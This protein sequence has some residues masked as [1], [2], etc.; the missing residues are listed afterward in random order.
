MKAPVKYSAILGMIQD[1][2]LQTFG[3]WRELFGDDE[4]EIG[5]L[6]DRLIERI[7][8]EMFPVDLDAAWE[9]YMQIGEPL[10]N[11]ALWPGSY[12]IVWEDGGIINH[13]WARCVGYPLAGLL[14]ECA[15]G[16]FDVLDFPATAGGYLEAHG[17]FLPEGA[18]DVCCCLDDMID[19]LEHM[20]PPLNGA[21]FVLQCLCRRSGHVFIDF[22]PYDEESA[23]DY[24]FGF[25]P[26]DIN[27]LRRE[28]NEIRPKV[29]QFEAYVTWFESTPLAEDVVLRAV[30]SAVY[31][32]DPLPGPPPKREGGREGPAGAGGT[33]DGKGKTL[34]EVF[35]ATGAFGE[36]GEDGEEEED[37]LG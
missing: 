29:E 4:V 26:D 34:I 5:D 37:D 16:M 23:F 21:A 31:G 17:I 28:Y 14:M 30:V 9:E 11:C 35:Q 25:N 15:S 24:E 27:R 10:V 18:A 3:L 12:S 36:E 22:S 7:H 1:E 13:E 19:V 33:W 2:V 32:V 6:E 20:R 8:E